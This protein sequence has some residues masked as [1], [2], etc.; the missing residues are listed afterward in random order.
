VVYSIVIDEST[1]VTHV[2]RLAAFICHVKEDFQF[3]VEL[4]DLVPKKG[5]QVLIIFL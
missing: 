4:S 5:T 3:V 1:D 2:A